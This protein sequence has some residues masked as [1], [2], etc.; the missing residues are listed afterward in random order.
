MLCRV[1]AAEIDRIIIESTQTVNSTR[2]RVPKVA[3]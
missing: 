2:I 3:S 1:T